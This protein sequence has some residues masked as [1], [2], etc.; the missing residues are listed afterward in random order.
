M[1]IGTTA[2]WDQGFFGSF[3]PLIVAKRL[4]VAFPEAIVCMEDAYLGYRERIFNNAAEFLKEFGHYPDA[5]VESDLRKITNY[6][7]KYSFRIRASDTHAASGCISRFCVEVRFKSDEEFPPAFQDR[8]RT[9]LET[10][11]FGEPRIWDG[12]KAAGQ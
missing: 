1:M 9:F 11:K 2:V 8:F 12:I 3:H 10:L 5:V 4:I 7:P 6:G